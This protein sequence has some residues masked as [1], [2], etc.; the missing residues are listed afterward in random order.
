MSYCETFAGVGGLT[1]TYPEHNNQ[2][3]MVCEWDSE[4]IKELRHKLGIEPCNEFERLKFWMYHAAHQCHGHN[5]MQ[6]SLMFSDLP[7][8]GG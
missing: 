5:T 6:H 1:A 3:T 8:P 2:A 4:N 7:P